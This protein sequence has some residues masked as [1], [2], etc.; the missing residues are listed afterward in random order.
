MEDQWT[1]S[2]ERSKYLR[3]VECRNRAGNFKSQQKTIFF[4]YLRCST[5]KRR[6]RETTIR[7]REGKAKAE[8][9]YVEEK[10]KGKRNLMK[11]IFVHSHLNCP[12][13]LYFQ[14][15]SQKSF[16]PPFLSYF[17]QFPKIIAQ[18]IGFYI[19]IRNVEGI[20]LP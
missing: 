18:S 2:D 12:K 6:E 14:K 10:G 4:F 3:R 11:D 17:W 7:E 5:R 13:T 8:S 1:A 16:N 20:K 15:L 19:Y 9:F